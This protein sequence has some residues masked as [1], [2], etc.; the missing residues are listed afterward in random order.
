MLSP[1]V[2]KVTTKIYEVNYSVVI[3]T[4]V[5]YFLFIM[6]SIGRSQWPSALR[7]GSAAARLLELRV[8]I[9]TGALRSLL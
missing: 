6:Q 4:G 1:V 3:R 8:R 9:P 2:S 5:A 7:R